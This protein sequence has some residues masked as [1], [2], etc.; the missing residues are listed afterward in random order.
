MT[1]ECGQESEETGQE[2]WPGG[3]IG[4]QQV[5]HMESP[6]GGQHQVQQEEEGEAGE[7]EGG[8]VAEQ[9]R[10]QADHAGCQHL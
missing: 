1:E 7:G 4:G 5:I 3:D 10:A 2:R 9:A 8:L 6:L